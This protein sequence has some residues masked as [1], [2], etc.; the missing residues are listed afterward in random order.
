MSGN[1]ITIKDIEHLKNLARVEFGEKET[2][3]LAK[4][5]G[6]ILGYIN[7]L[8]EV[9]TAN[10]P[11]MTYVHELSNIVREDLDTGYAATLMNN[12]ETISSLIDAFPEKENNFLKVK[13]IL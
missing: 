11:E 13:N 3:S 5:L 8:K 6:S 7:K 4:D 2:E 1:E 10:V 12:P 9:N